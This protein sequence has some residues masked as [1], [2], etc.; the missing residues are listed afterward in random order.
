M[1]I[2]AAVDWRNQ[3]QSALQQ[4]LGLYQ[5]QVLTLVHAVDLGSLDSYPLVP[6]RDTESYHEFE[7]A[8]QRLLVKEE[9]QL[10]QMAMR[11]Q[12]DVPSVKQV[13]EAGNPT[14]VILH[15]IET[16][17]A[18]LVV[19]G[20]RGLGQFT[21]LAMGSVSHLVLLHAA[22]ARLIVMGSPRTAS[23][24]LVAV[25]GPDDAKRLQGWL[26][27][28][29]FKRR[30]ELA[31]LNVVPTSE[32]ESF[33]RAPSL[34]TWRQAAKKSAQELVD[35][36]AAALNGPRYAATGRVAAGDPADVIAREVGMSDL[37]LVS[38]HGRTG[39][40]RLMFGSVSHSLVH[41][42]AGSVLVVP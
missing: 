11:L 31:V 9:R 5:P 13:C 37:L 39:V 8:K 41:R 23:R 3:S 16:T 22:C 17:A 28:Y 15:A 4:V 36:M 30:L 33:Q 27:T 26:L 42:V 1:N 38:S 20:K 2:L 7:Q 12:P 6:L 19:V 29:P 25:N 24:V 10:T 32:F 21:E 18:D 40:H 14:R 35:R 34:D